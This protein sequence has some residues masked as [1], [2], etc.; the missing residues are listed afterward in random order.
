MRRGGERLLRGAQHRSVKRTR[1][2]GVPKARAGGSHFPDSMWAG[3]GAGHSLVHQALVLEDAVQLPGCLGPLQL[4]PIQH[5][6]LQLLN[7]LEENG[8][9]KCEGKRCEL[10]A[11]LGCG[12]CSPR[13]HPLCSRDNAECPCL[14]LHRAIPSSPFTS[15]LPSQCGR[16]PRPLCGSVPRSRW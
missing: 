6:F 15:H 16:R 3:E 4:L 1:P 7:G 14:N 13:P 2:E 9:S 5:L 11:R 10:G 8:M 12:D